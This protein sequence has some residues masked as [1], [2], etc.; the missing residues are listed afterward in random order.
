[1]SARTQA[2]T[3][4]RTQAQT[5]AQSRS[6]S[7]E[8][9]NGWWRAALTSVVA[10]ALT[11]APVPVLAALAAW[12]IYET[13]TLWLVT[14]IAALVAFATVWL[15]VRLRWGAM[16]LVALAL[17]FLVLLLPLGV[18]G[19]LAGGPLGWLRGL[20]DG[21]AA[22]ALGWKQL[23]TLALPVGTYQTVLV[24]VLTVVFVAVAAATALVL[25]GGRW[26]PVAGVAYVLP[27]LFG[28]VFGSSAVS[29]PLR[30]GG[31]TV[32]AP[33]ELALWLAAVGAAVAWVAWSSGRARRQAL[34][35]GRE[36]DAALDAA[37]VAGADPAGADAAGSARP[38]TG[39]RAVRRNAAVRGL[40]AAVTVVAALAAALVVAPLVTQGARTVP[41]D[42]IDPELVIQDR[43]SPLAAYRA[44]KRDDTLQAELFSVTADG[45]RLP[46]R[47]TLAVLPEYD[48][49][50]FTVGQGAAA[51]R[52]ARFPSGGA[53]ADP[54][55]VSVEILGG[56][57]DVWVPI[58]APLGEPPSFTGSRA[59][60]LEDSFYLNRATGSA[61]A[62][63]TA[64]G[65]AA[66]DGYRVEM[67]AASPA[68]VDS[69]PAS[70]QPLVD[71]E[72][73]PELARWLKLQQLPETGEGLTTAIDRLRER[74]YLSHS[75]TDGAG[76]GLWLRDLAAEQGLRFVASPGGHSWS[77]VEQ[78]FGQLTE[79]QLAAG[80]DST[81]AMLVAGI[82][83]DEQFAAAAALVARA[84]GFDSR[85]VVG[86]R[87]GGE[88]DGV[89]GIPACATVCTGEHLAAWV[90]VA[91]ADGVWAPI[92]VSPQVAVPPTMLQK[93]EQ[94]PEFPTQP[95]DRDASE[96]DPPVGMSDQESGNDGENDAAGLSALWPVL[97]L[98]GLALLGVLLIAMLALFVPLVK[99]LRGRARRSQQVPELRALAAW[100]ELLDTYRDGGTRVPRGSRTDTMRQLGVDG[101]E[102]IAWTVDQ[103][104]Y[105]REGI[106]DE[107]AD[108][109]WEIVDA[110]TAEQWDDRS[111]WQRLMARFS[112]ASFG[113]FTWASV[114]DVLRRGRQKETTK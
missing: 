9:A 113:S 104:V 54:A 30:L 79:Q 17:G 91:G 47:L 32:A 25:R 96:S 5:Q 110:R 18:P 41:R 38:V 112:F 40:V 69:R 21:I 10:P 76:E 78:L 50:D 109:L 8:A 7:R 72:A 85:V 94:L 14:G 44:W 98:I 101:G 61:V 80:E 64:R 59:G 86:V 87:L 51:G 23:L 52:F 12:P 73:L 89:P 4:A 68:T 66:G 84:M 56:Y 106:T 28:T 6:R 65:L 90:E 53:I 100:D 75:L 60:Q 27:V 108:T 1:M 26:A 45:G 34:K 71:T 15:G 48:G 36:A 24:P 13:P 103:A 20:G 31:I 35:R 63:P 95:E 62:V 107:T 67:S 77:R 83:D 105:A 46:E 33:R 11:V 57:A 70:E 2:Q 43:V 29:A 74:G 16:T 22:V 81:Q 97:R 93:G 39:R 58:S 88:D 37:D 42:A 49:V 3:Q 19:A 111:V 82:G 114:R 99:R 92:D 55:R 102:W